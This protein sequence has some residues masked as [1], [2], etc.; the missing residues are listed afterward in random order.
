MH[1]EAKREVCLQ[2]TDAMVVAS[3]TTTDPALVRLASNKALI[4][5]NGRPAVSILVNNLKNCDALSKVILVGDRA[6]REAAPEA[7]VMIEAADVESDSI[8]AGIRAAG[9][10]DRML[11]LLADMPLALSGSRV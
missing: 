9:E 10:A 5:I 6:V 2:V 8:V 11:V 7:D 3:G 4:A 1:S